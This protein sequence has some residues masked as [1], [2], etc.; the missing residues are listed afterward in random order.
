MLEALQARNS[1]RTVA[2]VDMDEGD[3]ELF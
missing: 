1:Q 3:I 2:Q